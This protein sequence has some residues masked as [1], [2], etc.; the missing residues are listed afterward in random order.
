MNKTPNPLPI[1]V[2]F[3]QRGQILLFM[4]QFVE[5]VVDVVGD[6]IVSYVLL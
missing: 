1:Q 6:A 3:P 5:H 2:D 4:H